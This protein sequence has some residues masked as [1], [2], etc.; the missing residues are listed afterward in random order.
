MRYVDI[1]G[2]APLWELYNFDL[3]NCAWEPEGVALQENGTP[4]DPYRI[5]MKK[6]YSE[7]FNEIWNKHTDEIVNYITTCELPE[8]IDEMWKV[9]IKNF[10]IGHGGMVVIN[11]RKGFD[12]G[13]HADNR[14][15]LGVILVNLKDNIN[16]TEFFANP[17]KGTP[18]HKIYTAPTQKGSGWFMLNNNQL[19][20]IRSNANR[21]IGFQNLHVQTLGPPRTMWEKA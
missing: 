1:D 5:N 9:Y 18:D 15:I 14:A 19:H 2:V 4:V 6:P 17:I 3:P 11:D 20:R 7:K 10:H 12:M 13:W 16:G 8:V 21:M